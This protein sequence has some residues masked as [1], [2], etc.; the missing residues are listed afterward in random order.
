MKSNF[1]K[2][3]PEHKV[4]MYIFIY[5]FHYVYKYNIYIYILYF[6][7]VSSGPAVAP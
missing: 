5:I 7:N 1:T 6:Q 3:Y 2:K 4:F